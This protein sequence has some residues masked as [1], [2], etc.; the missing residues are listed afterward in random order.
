MTSYVVIIIAAIVIALLDDRLR[1][2][3]KVPPPTIPD[4]LPRTGRQ[5]DTVGGQF[6]IPPMR[7]IPGTQEASSSAE[8]ARDFYEEEPRPERAQRKG[9]KQQEFWLPQAR[10][11]QAPAQQTH[12]RTT[13][14]GTVLPT[15][16]TPNSMVQAVILSEVLGKPRAMRRFPRH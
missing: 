11:H 4:E 12:P 16:F 15:T 10:T 14:T 5:A 3:K 2:K 9:E 13:M 7:G 6:E 1:G 8:A